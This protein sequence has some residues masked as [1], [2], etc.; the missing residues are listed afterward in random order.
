MQEYIHPFELAKGLQHIGKNHKVFVT[1][2]Q[3]QCAIP[4]TGTLLH[5]M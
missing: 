2:Q 1:T 5:G 3:A 4:V